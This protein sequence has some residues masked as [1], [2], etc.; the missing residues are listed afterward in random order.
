MR[1]YETICMCYEIEYDL[2][3]HKIQKLAKWLQLINVICRSERDRDKKEKYIFL[4]SLRR[5]SHTKI[6]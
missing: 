1:D 2:M 3:I 5:K 4:Q 6:G